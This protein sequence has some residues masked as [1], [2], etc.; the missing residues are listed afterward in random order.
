MIL[1]LKTVC[2]ARRRNSPKSEYGKM[3]KDKCTFISILLWFAVVLS[4]LQA[5]GSGPSGDNFLQFPQAVRL[6]ASQIVERGY[7]TRE[8]RDFLEKLVTAG[9]VEADLLAAEK[10]ILQA[11][12]GDLPV[13]P[14]VNKALEGVAKSIPAARVITAM[15][16]VR[17]RYQLS[18]AQARS[19]PFNRESQGRVGDILAESL[20]AGLRGEDADRLLNGL[21]GR[22]DSG[23]IAISVSSVSFVRDM[24]RM[25]VGSEVSAEIAVSALS[26]GMSAE[27]IETMHASFLSQAQGQPAQAVALGI[28]H[29]MQHGQ[30]SQGQHG[31]SSSAS[32]G[33]GS[34]SQ[35]GSGSGSGGGGPGGGSGGG[36]AGGGGSGGGGSGGGGGGGGSGGGPGK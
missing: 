32:G 29:G 30:S 16:A 24:M 33:M 23:Q 3:T 36:G 18:Y 28:A 22:N 5:F 20:A 34:G 9:F 15:E 13:R 4:P 1:A 26:S 19:L 6:A 35:G 8:L 27:Q 12:T 21:K 14:I 17:S 25:G 31:Q 10:I 7:E 2:L 11:Q